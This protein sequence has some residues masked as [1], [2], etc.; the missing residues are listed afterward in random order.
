MKTPREILLEQRRSTAPKLDAIRREIVAGLNCQ[1]TKAQNWAVKIAVSCLAGSNKVWLELVWPC[2][3]IWAGLAAVWIALF[4]F[5]VSQRD[6]SELAARKLPP[7]SPEAIMTWRQQEKFLVELIG[8]SA[9]GDAE[10]REIFLPKPRT[11]IAEAV[12][13]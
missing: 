10:Q 8:P 3:R 6:K 7:P 11:E 4:I 2:R 13:V 1:D 12:A 5:N 9:P